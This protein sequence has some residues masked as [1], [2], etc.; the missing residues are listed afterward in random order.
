[1]SS[2]YNPPPRDRSPPRYSDHRP[3][4]NHPSGPSSYRGAGDAGANALDRAPP[5]GPK[6]E[7]FRG[8]FQYGSAHRGRGAYAGRPNDLW[9]RERDRDVRG[10]G[11]S[12]RREDDRPE[13]PRRDRDFPPS[14][15]G[16]DS[17]PFAARERSASPVR[18][19]RDSKDSIP[20]SFTRPSDSATSYYSVT[21]RGASIRGRGR[22][23]WDRGRGRSSFVGERGGDLFDNR[24]RSRDA[25]RGREADRG[26]G[27]GSDVDRSDRFERRDYDRS[28][29]TDTRP[30][31]YDS[32]QRDRSPGR[33]SVGNVGPR[34]ITPNIGPGTAPGSQ[35]ASTERSA[36]ADY[37]TG[38]RASAVITP[39]ATARDSRRDGEPGDYF[40][41]RV[42]TPRRDPPS[43]QA[44]TTPNTVQSAAAGALDYGPPPSVPVVTA[45]PQEKLPPPKPHPPRS[46]TVAAPPPVPFQPP[47]GPKAERSFAPPQGPKTLQQPESWMKTESAARPQRPPQN[48]S[49]GT[50]AADAV[51]RLGDTPSEHRGSFSGSADRPLPPNV[52]S[53]PR[54]GTNVSYK[55]RLASMEP[56]VPSGTPTAPRA[57]PKLDSRLANI[58]TGPRSER[59]KDS[60]QP[61]TVLGPP[62][63]S[64]WF[65]PDYRPKPSIMNPINKPYQSD[66]RD[67]SQYIPMAPRSSFSF[68]SHEAK[69]KM[70]QVTP[71]EQN[72]STDKSG[73]SMAVV[74]ESQVVTKPEEQAQ[75]QQ[76]VEGKPEVQEPV[77]VEMTIPSSDEDEME[78]DDGLDEEDF[79]A[80]EATHRREMDVLATKKPRP[81]FEYPVV[82]DFMVRIAML[83][84]IVQGHVPQEF[85]K[86]DALPKTEQH[87]D[88]RG[89]HISLPSPEDAA[90]ED[91]PQTQ[92]EIEQPIPRGRPLKQPL[93]NP[94]PTP[95]I[96]D[97][98]YLNR[99]TPNSLA[100]NESEDEVE[101]ESITT[102]LR[103]EF[104]HEAW[105]W[106]ENLED[107]ELSYKQNYPSW[108]REV[109]RLE[110]ERRRDEP[111]PAPASPAPSLVPSVSSSVPHE[112]TRGARNTTEADLQAA[113]LMSQQSLRE[114]EERREKEAAKN[115]R[116]NYDTEAIVP[117][118]LKPS[119]VE[120]RRFED[121]NK[122]IPVELAVDLFAYIPPEDDFTEEEQE[123]FIRAYCEAPKKWGKIAERIPGRDYHDCINHYYLTK[124]EAN[125]KEH[126]RKSQPKGKRGRKSAR[127]R[128]QALMEQ[129]VYNEDRDAVPIPVTDSG[130]PRR[131]AAPT[132]G[133]GMAEAEILVPL[134]ASK[135][136][137]TGLKEKDATGEPVIAPRPTRGRKA[138][139]ATRAPRKKTQIN[140][141]NTAAAEQQAAAMQAAPGMDALPQKPEKPTG[142]TERA[143]TLV[144][145]ESTASKSGNML[146]Q[147]AERQI[148][149]D[150]QNA[151]AYNDASMTGY[152]PAPS[153]ASVVT[154]YWSVPEQQKF[155]ELLGYYGHDYAAIADFMRTKSAIMIK[156]YFVRQVNDGK[157]DWEYIADH[158][159]NK[160]RSGE[161]MG[162]RPEPVAPPKR[163]YEATP[164]SIPRPIQS[165]LPVAES[166]AEAEGLSMA[167]KY[168]LIDDFPSNAL[169]RN[170]SGEIITKPRQIQEQMQPAPS[171]V[172]PALKVED[173][174]RS[175]RATLAQKPM[176]GPRSGLFQ[177]D[178]LNFSSPRQHLG[179]SLHD[180]QMHQHTPRTEKRAPETSQPHGTPLSGRSILS[181][182]REQPLQPQ[183]PPT[184]QTPAQQPHL[185]KYTSQ[186]MIQPVHSRGGSS[187]HTS[188][189]PIEQAQDLAAL[190]RAE[191]HPRN[192]PYGLSAAHPP[193]L[194]P[195]HQ[196][197][198]PRL[199]PLPPRTATPPT[200]ELPKPAPAKRSNIMSILNDD[201]PE[202]PPAKR[203]SL[204]GVKRQSMQTPPP[205]AMPMQQRL[206]QEQQSRNQI[207]HE[208]VRAILSRSVR[209]PYDRPQSDYPSGYSGSPAPSN[210]PWMDRFDPRHQ[211]AQ[212]EQRNLHHSPATSHY[213]VVP[214]STQSTNL[215]NL[216]RMPVEPSRQ[217][218]QPRAA[219]ES[220][221]RSLLSGINH[222]G[223]APSPPPQQPP[224]T[225][226]YRTASSSSQHARVSSLNYP[227]QQLIQSQMNLQVQQPGSSQP[228]NSHSTTST[229]VSALHQR[230]QSSLDYNN[231][232]R[233]TIQQ[234]MAQQ[235]Q[236]EQ[237]RRDHVGVNL[238]HQHQREIE[239][240][241]QQ[242]L[243]LRQ[244]QEQQRQQDL[245]HREMNLNLNLNMR[246]QQ[247][248]QLR[249]RP[250]LFQDTG[251]PPPIH[252]PNQFG[253]AHG[254]TQG[255]AST[256]GGH[257]QMSMHN[258]N[259]NH[260]Q[261]PQ[262]TYTPTP[263]AQQ[264]G[265]G[266]GGG[267]P[268][269]SHGHY[270][271]G[272]PPP[273]Q[274]Q[275]G[276]EQGPGLGQGQRHEQGQGQEQGQKQGHPNQNQS[277]Y[278]GMSQG[279]GGGRER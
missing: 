168:N 250:E 100:F 41:S 103:Q 35:Y 134:P 215:P 84:M 97:L 180:N 75:S 253:G 254:G 218:E 271:G 164:S 70:Q 252:H 48:T 144:R 231:P 73:D 136:L 34:A 178:L 239:L 258:H 275:P 106:R 59:D 210:D 29:D 192:L 17:R 225:Q 232:S 265:G 74:E 7:S 133:E 257:V 221:H 92:V 51:S 127:P 235:Q 266:G 156:N 62:S 104:E 151:A 187:A 91:D 263:T 96:E 174:P 71:A 5:R 245:R 273:H 108:K 158:A 204:D 3:S 227:H 175:E 66:V 162:P 213:S 222:P 61:R 113:I 262:R 67:R 269:H 256:P 45:A 94:I 186:R 6:A 85:I 237:R 141:V 199:D 242:D 170:A 24:S 191:P 27:P 129:L 26:R 148:D 114:E 177:D 241:Q 78:E 143:R 109:T 278:R 118:M 65:A 201:P 200:R 126:L 52:P 131:A 223:I 49:A 90:H 214:P 30:R 83:D 244:H 132:F 18:L 157:K 160:R 277:H 23:D 93:I 1:M 155:P 154:S 38:R 63:R 211:A 247:D 128:A 197:A 72:A 171:S 240:L 212:T 190:R 216:Q 248:Q 64:Q 50:L 15:R 107:L 142:R 243:N 32:W 161:D 255:H 209:T 76:R 165:S 249:R 226:P 274:Q 146:V 125:Y 9:D 188:Q 46:E 58:P 270:L 119:D 105:E 159:D 167:S 54:A 2:R 261:Q 166:M 4:A 79:A 135:R 139:T 138:G 189:I 272:P 19:R 43:V 47:S 279:G 36:R 149:V 39:T 87:E 169:Q 115:S 102:L 194:I 81:A 137:A 8:S 185:D 220:R 112:R 69:P 208:D 152:L 268:G 246:Q 111:S 21:P 44:Y 57:S 183:Q 130:R 37:D 55:P 16:R 196:V 80:S 117:P 260:Y 198:Q 60:V 68:Q 217:I 40:S 172:K 179:L 124:A 33:S 276:L 10:V 12:Y 206:L 22:G 150:M 145:V 195:M 230:N 13:W 182:A 116:P 251:V 259:H 122:L 123:L 14:D 264:M 229:P 99:N 203:T 233:M 77:D 25:Y 238:Q 163:R 173:A 140:A 98:P 193:G 82:L 181:Q 20:P 11:S 101:H 88:G 224:P 153:T 28:R 86:T 234:H 89:P 184:S 110:Q 120:L 207:G 56:V 176:Q 228:S 42:D 31:E 202:E 219:F 95:P 53:G 147:E 236:E 267:G 121:T 205:A